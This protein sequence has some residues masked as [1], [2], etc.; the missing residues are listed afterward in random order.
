[1]F[2]FSIN[3]SALYVMSSLLLLQWFTE[4][5]FVV[6]HAWMHVSV[7]KEYHV[8]SDLI[9]CETFFVCGHIVCCC[10]RKYVKIIL[11]CRV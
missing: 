9:C 5:E 4:I 11:I 7:W 1:M 6:P 10:T 2:S 3:W 8:L